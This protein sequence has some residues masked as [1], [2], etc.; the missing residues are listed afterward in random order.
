MGGKGGV[1]GQ[2]FAESWL[3][4]AEISMVAF[5]LYGAILYCD[6]LRVEQAKLLRI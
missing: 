5:S 3:F 1:G 6:I 4:S 2:I